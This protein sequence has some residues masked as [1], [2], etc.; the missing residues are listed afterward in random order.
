MLL[1]VTFSVLKALV[2]SIA[3]LPLQWWEDPVTTLGC[4]QIQS[5]VPFPAALGIELCSSVSLTVDN[6]SRQ[7]SVAKLSGKQ[8]YKAFVLLSRKGV[9]PCLK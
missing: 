3:F 7:L 6:V 5:S 8:Q 4:S 1:S 9:I 2:M